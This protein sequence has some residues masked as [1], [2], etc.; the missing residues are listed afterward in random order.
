MSGLIKHLLNCGA[1]I[2]A[3]DICKSSIT[4]ELVSLGVKLNFQHSKSN[5]K[6]SNVVV[7]TNAIASDNPELVYAW[8]NGIKTQ[9]R[10]ELLGQIASGYE[11]TIAVSG[12]HG[13]TTSTAMIAN[14]LIQAGLDPTVFL[15]GEDVNF[16]NYRW[17][18][19]NLVVLEACEYKKSFL[20]ILPTISVVLNV[21][22]DHMESYNG[23]GDMIESFSKFT[24]GSVLVVNADDKKLSP[25]FNSTTITFGIKNSANYVAK[26]ITSI[27]PNYAFSVYE[28]GVYKGRI[29]LSVFG[30]H[31][32]YNALA[33]VAVCEQL[34]IPFLVIKSALESFKGVK[35]RNELI[36]DYNGLS[37]Y[38]DYAHHPSEITA[39]LNAYQKG[40]K[41]YITVFQPH[42]YSRTK[43]LMQDFILAL[44]DN[45]PLIIMDTYPAR[46]KFD[47]LGSAKRLYDNIFD[48][49]NDK[50]QCIFVKNEDELILAIKK[51]T[52]TRTRRIIFLGAGDIYQKAKNILV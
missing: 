30:K 1:T 40:G 47:E 12:S 17:G 22:N 34:K 48:C 49:I 50:N 2:S 36:G 20:D 10:S 5:V 32:I 19:G 28:S 3:S 33:C 42:T 15:G 29:K 18:N 52:S 4:D 39:T 45:L 46:E 31:N 13:K 44:K 6:N 7:Y 51:L 37:C 21:D 16:G 27:G 41:D 23:F 8:K 26:N 35:R 11:T 24:Q 9:K 25:I 38:A 14:V 43:L